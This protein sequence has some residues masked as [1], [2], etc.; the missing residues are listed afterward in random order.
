[1]I[2]FIDEA[3]KHL[4]I[5]VDLVF[6][7]GIS[8]TFFYSIVS[9]LALIYGLI[10]Q[11]GWVCTSP[12]YLNVCKKEARHYFLSTPWQKQLPSSNQEKSWSQTRAIAMMT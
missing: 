1:M 12:M 9:E 4:F 8:L 2:Q 3:S 7:R 5:P 6:P 10:G 11:L